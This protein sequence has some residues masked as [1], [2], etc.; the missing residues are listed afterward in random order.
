VGARTEEACWAIPEIAISGEAQGVEHDCMTG[1]CTRLF[2]KTT[3]LRS[4]MDS[5]EPSQSA[6]M[7]KAISPLIART[8][9]EQRRRTLRRAL[10]HHVRP[11]HEQHRSA[12]PNPVCP[13]VYRSQV[14][15]CPYYELECCVRRKRVQVNTIRWG[16]CDL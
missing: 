12:R 6:S 9:A 1:P 15:L 14:L 10:S 11:D 3:I 2:V 16:I 5:N 8:R 7:S 13:H 4:L